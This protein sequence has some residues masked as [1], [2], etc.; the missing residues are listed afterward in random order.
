[1]TSEPPSRPRPGRRQRP[2]TLLG[3]QPGTVLIGAALAV[4]LLIA[5]PLLPA[6]PRGVIYVGCAW[7]AVGLAAYGF[8][9]RPPEL[10]VTWTFLLTGLLLAAIANTLFRFEEPDHRSLLPQLLSSVG[11]LTLL[12]ATLTLVVR[13]GAR[14]LGGLIDAALLALALG[15]LVLAVMVVPR[16]PEANAFEH[17]RLAITLTFS[18]SMLGALLRLIEVDRSRNPALRLLAVSVALNLLGFLLLTILMPNGRTAGQTAFLGAYLAVIAALVGD[19]INRLGVPAPARP[20]RLSTPGLVLLGAALA[21]VPVTVAVQAIDGRPISGPL[22][23]VSTVLIVPLVMMRLALLM[24]E[25]RRS[26]AG[27]RQQADHD[28]LTAAL[29]RR[30]FTD[31]I[32][33]ELDGRRG[34]A[35]VFCDLDAFKDVNDAHG[36][37]AGDK[38]LVDIT[39]RLRACIDLTD[40]LCRYGGDEFAILLGGGTAAT[41][42]ELKARITSAMS[43]P[44]RIGGDQVVISMSLGAVVYGGADPRGVSPAQLIREADEAM[45][46]Q[47]RL[48]VAGEHI[49]T[50]TNVV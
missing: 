12:A 42:D 10:H 48:R 17:F 26:Q 36:H 39:G 9:R 15:G 21:L 24:R 4:A 2:V 20:D 6:V 37:W 7:T 3:A 19:G 28:A 27:L 50:R 29:N 18:A 31:A 47:K 45:Y 33:E 38:V 14:D 41:V 49:A 35:L 8:R 34:F 5:Y 13:R 22:L 25:L 32:Q 16:L 11:N 46:R 23:I 44:F 40:M 43:Y 1:M 30:A